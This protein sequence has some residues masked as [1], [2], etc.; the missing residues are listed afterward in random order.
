[1]SCDEFHSASA[2][3]QRVH[4]EAFAMK[5]FIAA[6]VAASEKSQNHPVEISFSIEFILWLFPG[7]IRAN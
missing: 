6:L 7:L 4:V 5:L 2:L 3:L 1:M